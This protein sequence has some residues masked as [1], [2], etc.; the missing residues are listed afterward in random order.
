VK[1][2]PEIDLEIRGKYII[3]SCKLHLSILIQDEG[4]DSPYESIIGNISKFMI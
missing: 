3:H 1:A 2:H 4:G